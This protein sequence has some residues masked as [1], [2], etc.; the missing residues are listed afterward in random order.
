VTAK[1]IVAISG[2]KSMLNLEEQEIPP[3]IE[4]KRS[5]NLTCREF[6]LL[7]CLREF[8][9]SGGNATVILSTSAYYPTLIGD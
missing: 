7:E 3:L 2:N 8:I 9:E 6:Y 1:K 5:T 4:H